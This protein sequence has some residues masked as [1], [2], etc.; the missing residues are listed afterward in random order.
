MRQQSPPPNPQPLRALAFSGR[1][2]ASG[3]LF[4]KAPSSQ[5]V[6]P[7]PALAFQR[8][9][10]R[11]VLRCRSGDSH[12]PAITATKSPATPHPCVFGSSVCV[13]GLVFQSPQLAAR[14]PLPCPRLP[15]KAPACCPRATPSEMLACCESASIRTLLLADTQHARAGAYRCP[16]PSG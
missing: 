16:L 14:L 8:R 10:L 12:A 2:S 11:A 1:R 6:F 4:L 3:G 13:W 15:E 9:L 7:F 5:P